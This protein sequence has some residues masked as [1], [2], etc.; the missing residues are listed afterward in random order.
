MYIVLQK[1]ERPLTEVLSKGLERHVN[2]HSELATMSLDNNT[3]ETASDKHEG[4]CRVS[5]ARHQ[6]CVLIVGMTAVAAKLRIESM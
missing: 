2:Q 4:T 6:P 1:L 5:I 3:N